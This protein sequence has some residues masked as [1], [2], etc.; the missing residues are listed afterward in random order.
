[1]GPCPHPKTVCPC[2]LCPCSLGGLGHEAH[3]CSRPIAAAAWQL[4]LPLQGPAQAATDVK[5]RTELGPEQTHSLWPRS[6]L[7]QKQGEAEGEEK[8]RGQEEKGSKGPEAVW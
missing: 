6:E 5:Y 3:V 1:M 4:Q 2:C 8:G 7:K